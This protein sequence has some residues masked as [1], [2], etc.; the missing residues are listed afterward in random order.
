MIESLSLL[1]QPNLP[2]NF[3]IQVANEAG[4]SLAKLHLTATNISLLPGGPGRF[5]S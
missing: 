3:R 2:G 5:C 1:A 4:D